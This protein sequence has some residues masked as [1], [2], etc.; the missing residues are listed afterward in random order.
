M[1][2]SVEEGVRVLGEKEAVV[3]GLMRDCKG[4]DKELGEARNL[5]RILNSMLEAANEEIV[6]SKIVWLNS[7][8]V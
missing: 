8:Y 4:L 3:K 2:K 7:K 6:S 1:H 5:R